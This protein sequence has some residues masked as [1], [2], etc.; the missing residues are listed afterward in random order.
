MPEGTQ[1]MD[2]EAIQ[3][4]IEL[5][6]SLAYDMV[7]S[8]MK[9]PAT[10]HQIEPSSAIRE[11]QKEAEEFMYRPPRLGV[12]APLPLG[13]SMSSMKDTAKLKG[14]LV[15]S[16][17]KRS[18]GDYE[19]PRVNGPKP[20]SSDEEEDSRAGALGQKHHKGEASLEARLS[21]FDG[22]GKGKKKKKQ[23]WDMK[24]AS[25]PVTDTTDT[26]S[27]LPTPSPSPPSRVEQSPTV[28][29]PPPIMSSSKIPNVV[30]IASPD[31]SDG[32]SET[33]GASDIA[34]LVG[35]PP[36][37]GKGKRRR[38]RKKKRKHRVDLHQAPGT[39]AP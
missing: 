32:E 2:S 30:F 35:G 24:P 27:G 12:G 18:R 22:K 11:A 29:N 7:S 23:N 31:D 19:G 3:S 16:S 17:L 25:T 6:F 13:A 15:A 37:E 14:R 28:P 21:V 38:N 10:A 36:A 9:K 8:W 1:E 33:R 4:Q 20:D 34:T 5:S 26:I 39:S